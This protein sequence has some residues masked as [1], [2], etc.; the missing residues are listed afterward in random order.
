MDIFIELI[1]AE[2]EIDKSENRWNIRRFQ[3]SI[4]YNTKIKSRFGKP[5]VS[6]ELTDK[7]RDEFKR[8]CGFT[9]IIK[10]TVISD[11]EE[12]NNEEIDNNKTSLYEE[13][14]GMFGIE[15]EISR[16]EVKKIEKFE[17]EWE[18]VLTEEFMKKWQEISN[19]KKEKRMEEI[20]KWYKEN[21]TNC[22]SCNEPRIKQYM[23]KNEE[24]L[25]V[26][27]DCLIKEFKE[28]SDSKENTESN[29]SEDKSIDAKI[30]GRRIMIHKFEVERLK[31]LGFSKYYLGSLGFIQE[32]KEN[33][34]K[35][36]EKLIE[37]LKEW[38]KPVEY[39]DSDIQ[40][41]DEEIFIEEKEITENILEELEKLNIETNKNEIIRL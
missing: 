12:E 19:L 5:W 25:I 6:E 7:I 28:K 24:K 33:E 30:D 32:Y 22:K 20:R 27:K 3:R 31:R 18:I 29:E 9:K 17:L 41:D 13:L 39:N 34:G 10:E 14:L 1:H 23:Y 4:V 15:Y 38:K 8:T 26:C 40:E 21:V 36:D 11:L 16:S 37:I 2:E 35:S